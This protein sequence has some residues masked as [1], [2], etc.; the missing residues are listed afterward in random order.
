MWI[1]FVFWI[2]IIW[3]IL[4]AGTHYGYRRAY[5]P[6]HTYGGVLALWL[7]LLLLFLIFIGPWWGYYGY[8]W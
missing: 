4:S 3:L 1:W 6:R 2:V 8:W 5:Y 7:I